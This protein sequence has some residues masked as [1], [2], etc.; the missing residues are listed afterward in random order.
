MKPALTA[1][2]AC[3]V[4]LLLF[5]GCSNE[6]VT[7]DQMAGT[8]Q[9]ADRQYSLSDM[10]AGRQWLEKA[11]ALQQDNSSIYVS[12]GDDSG[13][14]AISIAYRYGD[15]PEVIKIASAARNR[16]S[17]AKVR[18]ALDDSLADAYSRMGQ[19][20]NS[21]AAYKDE[22]DDIIAATTKVG[23][24]P[25]FGGQSVNEVRGNAEWN[26]GDH[27]AGRSDFIMAAT[28]SADQVADGQN[29][30]AYS[31]AVSDEDL[32][33][34]ESLARSAVAYAEKVDDPTDMGLYRDTL[35]WVLHQE[36]KNVEAL[37]YSQLAADDL[38]QEGDIVYHLAAIYESLGQVENARSAYV[39][40]VS[41]E[42]FDSDAKAALNRLAKT[43]PSA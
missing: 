13:P 21:V 4:A 15:Y 27:A 16:K 12:I 25:D 14:S 17:L 18:W 5:S 43:M 19:H 26:A 41:L 42:P 30:L 39:R 22:V 1:I 24:M 9:E 32:S 23:A 6:V 8:L 20:T 3:A 36:G 29:A 7:A 2:F 35:A 40:V 11:I 28:G 37:P 38:P 34:A 33:E 31:E 10:N